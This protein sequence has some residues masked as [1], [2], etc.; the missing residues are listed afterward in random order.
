MTTTTGEKTQPAVTP[1]EPEPVVSPLTPDL[2]QVNTFLNLLDPDAKK[3]FWQ[4]YPDVKNNG[5]KPY[6]ATG[7]VHQLWDKLCKWNERG[8]AICVAVNHCYRGR[9]TENIIGLR[10]FWAEADEPL[11]KPIPKELIGIT[12]ESSPG[13]HHYYIL[14]DGLDP[15]TDKLDARYNEVNQYSYNGQGRKT[16]L[17]SNGREHIKPLFDSIQQRIVKDYGSDKSAALLNQ[18]MRVPG[19]IH[20]KGEPFMTRLIEAKSPGIRLSLDTIMEAIPPL[21]L[22]N[23]K[24]PSKTKT[25][26]ELKAV[27]LIPLKDQKPSDELY[28]SIELDQ[29]KQEKLTSSK[30]MTH[31]TARDNFFKQYDSLPEG[32]VLRR[33]AKIK[34]VLSMLDPGMERD[35]WI[36]VGMTLHHETEG[37]R[38]GFMFW[39]LW[40]RGE[41]IASGEP[42]NYEDGACLKCWKSF[43]TD[44]DYRPLSIR[45]LYA[46]LPRDKRRNYYDQLDPFNETDMDFLEDEARRVKDYYF[47][48]FAWMIEGEKVHI[49]RSKKDKQSSNKRALPTFEFISE[50][51]LD[52]KLRGR[53]YP[54]IKLD[55]TKKSVVQKSVFDWWMSNE[56][57][58]VY[59]GGYFGPVRPGKPGHENPLAFLDDS[60]NHK[61]LPKPDEHGYLNYYRGMTVKP[62]YRAE[63][64]EAG[65]ADE[66]EYCM[67]WIRRHVRGILCGGDSLAGD[68]FENWLARMI[69]YPDEVGEVVTVFKS[70][71]GTGKSTFTE[72]LTEIY[73]DYGIDINN[74]QD[75]ESTFNDVYVENV[76]LSV[77]EASFGTGAIIKGKLRGLI[78]NRELICNP[79]N[80]S[81][82]TV[83]NYLHM[84]FTSNEEIVAP[85]GKLDRRY[86]YFKVSDAVMRDRK[87]FIQLRQKMWGNNRF[88]IRCYLGYLMGLDVEEG[89][90]DI[91]TPPVHLLDNKAE[92]AFNAL[93]SHEQWMHQILYQGYIDVCPDLLIKR[94]SAVHKGELKGLPY[95][96][97]SSGEHVWLDSYSLGEPTRISSKCLSFSYEHFRRKAGANDP[98]VKLPKYMKDVMKAVH[99]K[100]AV[101]R[102][103]GWYMPS[104]EDLRIRWE[105]NSG[106]RGDWP[107]AA[108]EAEFGDIS[109]EG[110]K[111]LA[112]SKEVDFE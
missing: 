10:A 98:L 104:L 23:N 63:A 92:D 73:G 70:D 61:L 36:N 86:V 75:L 18:V 38:E 99:M 42:D 40:S 14:L 87:H 91:G 53:N 7:S 76:F 81:Q 29:E 3:W 35:Q 79:K 31:R 52:K 27:N 4:A 60:D 39:E 84:I 109:Y 49:V 56:Q 71:P 64:E 6:T 44:P 100:N 2:V 21:K 1:P 96:R 95:G 67:N 20:H 15:K 83:P 57:T 90:F 46:M 94:K 28:R 66:Y 58:W 48:Q 111:G 16:L 9:K 55:G 30:P 25:K 59:D 77:S 106:I 78:T 13:K 32:A 5:L 8:Y 93:R 34:G 65:L 68:Y 33:P 89:V 72:M 102:N 51:G 97:G 24:G 19:F 82:Y 22:S 105:K 88:G 69:Q 74:M 50:K 101:A 12:V 26:K 54:Q 108:S 107:D 62:I 80:K 11:I 43:S 37:G 41:W 45:T 17:D 47:R 85:L 112:A 103:Y 110:T